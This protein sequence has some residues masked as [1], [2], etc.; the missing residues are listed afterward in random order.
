[1]IDPCDPDATSPAWP[2]DT[3]PT[4]APAVLATDLRAALVAH[5]LSLVGLT[6]DPGKPDLR[7]R[8]LATVA[9]GEREHM[10]SEMAK[11][12]GCALTALRGYLAPFISHPITSS[13]YVIGAAVSDLVRVGREA[14]AIR[15]VY[16]MPNAG[17][18]VIVGGGADGGGSEHAW[19]S[20][21]EGSGVDG[22]QPDTRG[23]QSIARRA[24]TIQAG[25][26]STP[27]YRRK[28]RFVIDAAKV[29]AAF[30]R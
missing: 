8:Y 17:D 6:A 15:D 4:G 9:P 11:M 1:M 2:S 16:T 20:I 14:H 29:C 28:V 22:G 26:D 3:L 21:G 10:A 7:A 27:T 30:P 23:F 5:A 12:S 18:V 24:H 13:P 19:I 25:W